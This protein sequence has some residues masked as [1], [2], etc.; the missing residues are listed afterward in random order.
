MMD[1]DVFKCPNCGAPLDPEKVKGKYKCPYCLTYL[2]IKNKN[3]EY[4]HEI[5]FDSKSMQNITSSFS[6]IE[7]VPVKKTAVSLAV[8]ALSIIILMT[9]GIFLLFHNV[10]SSK[11]FSENREIAKELEFG[12]EGTGPGYFQDVRLVLTTYDG[13]IVTC[14]YEDGRI[15]VF[16]SSMNFLRQWK[17]GRKTYV[18]SF[19]IDNSGKL[20]AVVQ[21]DVFSYD[22][23]DGTLI[24]SIPKNVLSTH[25]FSEVAVCADGYIYVI[26]ESE[27]LAK[28]DKNKN[29]VWTIQNAV[30]SHSDDSELDCHLAVDGSGYVYIL[31]TF[32][33]SVFRFSPEGKFL[34]R[35]GSEGNDPGSI[36]FAS[37]SI[38]VDNQ[39]NIYV[40]DNDGIEVFSKDGKFLTHLSAEA[41][42]YSMHI[43][44]NN[45]LFTA[46]GDRIVKYTLR[47]EIFG[48]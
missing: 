27:N 4:D 13:H 7:V 10:K 12:S 38:A 17:T 29:V 14:E 16:D 34:N 20:F 47:P 25:Y 31:G 1:K 46:N 40:S 33:C 37:T 41:P 2:Q 48:N 30:S 26:Y 5:T 36:S 35:I 22:I 18:Q 28:V 23:A 6:S 9:S 8:I 42:N 15:Q 3:R 19:S 24:D 45:C 11:T 44:K 43:D 21:G 32:N 39:S